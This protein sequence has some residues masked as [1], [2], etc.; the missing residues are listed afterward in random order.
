MNKNRP[1]NQTV[2]ISGC[3]LYMLYRICYAVLCCSLHFLVYSSELILPAFHKYS[4]SIYFYTLQNNIPTYLVFTYCYFHKFFVILLL[5]LSAYMHIYFCRDFTIIIHFILLFN[6]CSFS[7]CVCRSFFY[8][9]LYL[10][11]FLYI[12]IWHVILHFV[13]ECVLMNR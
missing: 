3:R 6:V 10:F 13:K 7:L 9:T 4:V 1:K 12:Y 5:C 8:P 2:L 11:P